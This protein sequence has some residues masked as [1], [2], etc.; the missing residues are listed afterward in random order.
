M[1]SRPEAE[2]TTTPVGLVTRPVPG[3]RVVVRDGV[4]LLAERLQRA[5]DEGDLPAGHDP[6]LLARSLVTVANGIAVQAA[7][8][9]P[10]DE[11]RRVAELALLQ[12]PSP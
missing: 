2:L 1:T 10:R 4:A 12:W 3:G 8:G 9:T 11:L 5:A 7:G 6:G